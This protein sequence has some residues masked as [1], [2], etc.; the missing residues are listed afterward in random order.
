MLSLLA[1]QAAISLENAKLYDTLDT[2][3]KERTRELSETLHHLQQTQKQLI[4]QEKLASLGSLTSG[5]AHEIKNPLNFVNNFAEFTVSLVSELREELKPQGRAVDFAAVE[6]LLGEVEHNA[7]KIHEH[8]ARADR[9]VRA[10]LEHARTG[11]GTIREVNVNELVREY[12]NL[13]L[14]SHRTH[15]V[16]SIPSSAL[17]TGF[18]ESL[19]LATVTSEDLGRVVLNL[20]NN[21]LYALVARGGEVGHGFTPLLE[22]KTRDLG[23]RFEIRIRDNGCGIPPQAKE[24][25]FTPF[26]TTKPPGQGTGLGLSIS[27]DIV[28]QGHGGTMSFSSQEGEG[29]EFVVALPKRANATTPDQD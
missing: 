17:R 18:D 13:A 28:V 27:H 19:G 20:T 29:T 9:I 16:P 4:L 6:Q 11:P 12:V 23:D 22:V 21:A 3:V 8:G 24:R 5:I 10:M 25:I 26:F 1:A 2:R 15:S 7:T 14:T